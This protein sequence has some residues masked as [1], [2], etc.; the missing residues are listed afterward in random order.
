MHV[1]TCNDDAP[2]HSKSFIEHFPQT[3]LFGDLDTFQLFNS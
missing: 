3:S 2:Q 1:S